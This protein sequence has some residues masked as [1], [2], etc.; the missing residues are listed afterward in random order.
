MP[1]KA[2]DPNEALSLVG[3]VGPKCRPVWEG[4]SPE[5][6][7]ALA[8]YFLPHSSSK[9]VLSPTHPRV[10]KWYCPFASQADFPTGHR[11]CINVFTGCDH[12]CVYCYAAGYE[13]QQA[14]GKRNFRKLLDK[15]MEEL[16]SFDVPPAPVHLS[17]STDPFQPL[18]AETGDAR[19]ALE[20]IL[21][22]RNRFTTVMV[23]TKN[24]L[25]PV[26][27]GYVEILRD[28]VPLPAD[29][30]RFGEFNER[31]LPGFCMEISLAF[32]R[33]EARAAYDPKAPTVEERKEGIRALHQAGIPLVLRIDPLFP[34]SPFTRQPQEVLDDF[35][36][37]EAQTIDDLEKLVLFAREIGARHVVYSS[38]KITL[39]RQHKLSETMQAIRMVY[40][41]LTAPEKLVFRGGSW[42]LPQHVAETEVLGEF[43]AICKREDMPAKHCKQNLLETP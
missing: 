40:Q 4:R 20:Q 39:P 22:H 25:R 7:V 1:R 33:D 26:R 18:E 29:D 15:D 9:E 43:L 2:P 10:I 24:P 6:Q 17:N 35:A 42:R 21:A 38:A 5:E 14:S 30:P 32:W 8:R 34:L 36:L 11:Y 31:D 41:H 37:P 23:L 27:L 3:K 28:L 19:Y 12:K 13:P 16:E